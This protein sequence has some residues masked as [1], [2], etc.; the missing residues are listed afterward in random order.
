MFLGMLTGGC[1]AG[2]ARE[3]TLLETDKFARENRPQRPKKETSIEK[4]YAFSGANLLFSGRAIGMEQRVMDFFWW[5]V[6][7]VLCL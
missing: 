1:A 3:S 4:M 7:F 6:V 5:L 2:D